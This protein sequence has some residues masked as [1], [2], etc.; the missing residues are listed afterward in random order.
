MPS[1]LHGS[2]SC[3][4]VRRAAALIL[5]LAGPSSDFLVGQVICF[6]DGWAG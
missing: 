6:T 5:F 4:V 2:G 3:V 1:A